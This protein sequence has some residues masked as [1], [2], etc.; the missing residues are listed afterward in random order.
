AY[1]RSTRRHVRRGAAAGYTC[2]LDADLAH[3]PVVVDLY[4]S[5]MRRTGAHSRYQYELGYFERLMAELGDAARLFVCCRD[6]EVLAGSVYLFG[7]GR[8]H[9]HRGGWVR[10]PGAPSPATFETDAV[11]RWA[12][13][14]GYRWL[15]LGGGVGSSADSLLDYKLAFSSTTRPFCTWRWI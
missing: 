13:E 10:E 3:L 4:L 9:A 14:Q 8:F 7:G 5:T 6:G 15:N 1:H 2:L 11:R 12:S